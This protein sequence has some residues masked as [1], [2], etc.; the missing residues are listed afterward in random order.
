MNYRRMVRDQVPPAPPDTCE[1]VT[2]PVAVVPYA[3]GALEARTPRHI[4]AEGS[5]VRGE[6]LIRRLQL[7][8]LCGGL[9]ELLESNNRLYRMLDTAIFGTGYT[10]T[11][12][13]PLVVVP[14]IPPQRT[15]GIYGDDSILGRMEDMRQLLQ[16]ALNGTETP[17][18]DRNNGVRDLLEQLVTAIQQTGQLDDDMLNKLAEIAVLVA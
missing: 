15:M 18:Y 9:Q 5:Y 10:V 16:N 14:E 12:T 6:Q 3:L 4:W 2:F 11:S 8:L 13:D 1:L 17:N 7:A